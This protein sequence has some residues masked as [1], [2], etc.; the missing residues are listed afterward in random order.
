M[1]DGPD[2]A[3]PGDPV[4]AVK[5]PLR[6]RGQRHPDRGEREPEQR[7]WDRTRLGRDGG[8]PE[9]D[10]QQQSAQEVAGERD[11][12]VLVSS[13]GGQ[14]GGREW[15]VDGDPARLRQLG[16]AVPAVQ[17]VPDAAGRQEQEDVDRDRADVPVDEHDSIAAVLAELPA[18]VEVVP[19]SGAE[20]ASGIGVDG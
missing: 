19:H 8:H 14:L 10:Q 11:E 1:V 16:V 17:Q 5:P 2:P 7:D 12:R 18:G 6:G 15:L 3:E 13:G 9:P 20:P 4:S